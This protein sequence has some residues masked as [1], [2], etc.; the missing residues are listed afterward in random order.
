[1]RS[2]T[3]ARCSRRIGDVD[4]QIQPKL[5]KVLEEQRFRRLGETR[6]A[7]WTCAVSRRITTCRGSLTEGTFRGDLFF[8]ISTI[9]LQPATPLLAPRGHSCSRVSCSRAARIRV[10]RRRDRRTPGIRL[11]GQHPR[12]AERARA[13]TCSSRTALNR[14]RPSAVPVPRKALRE[15]GPRR[16]TLVEV[17]RTS[18][19]CWTSCAPSSTPPSA[20]ASAQPLYCKMRKHGIRRVILLSL[21]RV[22][23]LIFI[24]PHAAPRGRRSS[25]TGARSIR[26]Q[27]TDSMTLIEAPGVSPAELSGASVEREAASIGRLADMRLRQ[28]LFA[29]VARSAPRARRRRSCAQPALHAVPP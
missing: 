27:E 9:T 23:S 22:A 10:V 28:T 18:S 6:D 26:E 5:L 7:S 12:A 21:E 13:R 24:T 17:E 4:L 20:S 11:A 15:P 16:H 25:R 3:R 2:P 1:V 8:R 29:E 19:A 14:S